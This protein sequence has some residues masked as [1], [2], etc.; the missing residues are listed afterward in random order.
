MGIVTG[1]T[2]YHFLVIWRS[3]YHDLEIYLRFRFKVTKNG[4]VRQ[5]A[6]EF[7]LV[8]HR[9]LIDSTI[10]AQ[11]HNSAMQFEPFSENTLSTFARYRHSTWMR[12]LLCPA[13]VV[14]LCISS[15]FWCA[16]ESDLAQNMRTWPQNNCRSTLQTQG[17]ET[18][19]VAEVIVPISWSIGL[20]NTMHVVSE[21]MKPY[22]FHT[23]VL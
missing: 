8:F 19:P 3:K 1:S 9:T 6:Y 13:D 16:C 23:L 15:Y 22:D 2:A 4:V 7:L 14:K 17:T 11:S 12:G 10:R 20:H 21:I 18:V 5:I